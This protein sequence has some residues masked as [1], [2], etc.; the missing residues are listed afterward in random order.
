MM[1]H[2]I[3][4]ALGGA[5]GSV[6]RFAFNYSFHKIQLFNIA[7]GTLA[8]NLSGSLLIGIFLGYTMKHAV[9][10]PMRLF[11]VTGILGGFTTFSAFSLENMQLLKD[12]DF[13]NLLFNVLIQNVL[14]ILLA[15]AG[16]YSGKTIAG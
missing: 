15:L 12:G 3:Y 5:I 11:L 13:R 8:A 16:F 4:V 9:S 6:L 7:A 10:D 1:Q 2:L 14:G